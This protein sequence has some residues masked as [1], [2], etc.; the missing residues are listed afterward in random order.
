[1]NQPCLRMNGRARTRGFTLLEVLIAMLVLSFGLLGLAALQAYSVKANQSANFR[2]QATALA[3][4]MLDNIRSNRERLGDY[5]IDDYEDGF[6]CGSDPDDSS[7]GAHDLS[8]WRIQVNCQLPEGRAAVAPISANEVAVCI[9]W[10]DERWETASGNADGKCT[11]DAASFGAGLT[12]DGP[13]AGRDG[14]FSVFVVSSR[15]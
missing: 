14:Q 1:M 9:R 3:N 10:S 15:M 2:S 4:M 13:G 8:V 5:Y 7:V 11:E 12:A 6:D